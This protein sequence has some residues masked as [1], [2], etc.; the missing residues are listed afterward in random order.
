MDQHSPQV[1]LELPVFFFFFFINV[2]KKK[3]KKEVD[4]PAGLKRQ[5][6]VC[7]SDLKNPSFR[8]GGGTRVGETLERRCCGEACGRCA[9]MQR[10][11]VNNSPPSAVQSFPNTRNFHNGR[12]ESRL[13]RPA[14]PSPHALFMHTAPAINQI[15]TMKG[16]F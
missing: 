10:G 14:R 4:T 9:R 11:V 8:G 2:E 12:S 3:K 16:P 15:I 13:P 7:V 6:P 1:Q 5:P